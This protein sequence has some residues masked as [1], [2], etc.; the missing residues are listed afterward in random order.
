MLVKYGGGS[1]TKE[2]PYRIDYFDQ[3][4][5]MSEE[6]ARGYFRQTAD[7][8]FPVWASHTPIHTVT[9]QR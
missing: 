4:E 9:C 2:D 5:P 6:K 3:L 7:I 1:G 8:T